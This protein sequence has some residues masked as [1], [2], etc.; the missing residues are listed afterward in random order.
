MKTHGFTLIELLIAIIL[1]IILL[2][3]VTMIFINTTETVATS[4]A[5]NHVYTQARFAGDTIET[6]VMGSLPFNGQQSFSLDDGEGGFDKDG[7][8]A[9]PAY[10]RGSSSHATRAADRLMFR[11]TT[12]VGDT[13][14]TVQVEYFLMP[15]NKALSPEG[16]IVEGDPLRG[17]T[18]PSVHHP[19]GRPLYT[20]MRRI[21][22]YNPASGYFDTIPLDSWQR[23]VPDM[24]LCTFV[25][26]FN[27]EYFA[28]NY[29]FS[30]LEPSPFRGDVP[31]GAKNDPLG[32]GQGENDGAGGPD[33]IP[34]R[35]PMIRV[36]LSIVE[37]VAARQER[38]IQKIIY[39]PMG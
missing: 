10:N 1:T 6:D 8:A 18:L 13:I 9:A 26:S 29:Q 16:K 34:L 39:L 20:L 33:L 25:T 38:T 35:V 5:R 15:G 12:M 17:R 37:D 22:A 32:N 19:E 24:E 28:S 4:Q 30:Q 2:S 27:L 11:A 31:P 23:P 21:R 36:T 3:A 14:Q 7:G